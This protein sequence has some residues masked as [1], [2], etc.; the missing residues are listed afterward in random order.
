MKKNIFHLST[1]SLLLLI[2]VSCDKEEQSVKVDSLMPVNTGNTRT[3]KYTYFNNHEEN[4]DT[5]VITI[6]EKVL[7]NGYTCFAAA[8]ESPFNA[9]FLA[10]NDEFGNFVSYGGL[11]D[12]D[13]LVTPSI[14]FKKDAK[15]GDE[16]E[17]SMVS[18][19]WETG[20]FSETTI[21]VKC[22]SVDTLITTPKGD[23][24]CMAFETSINSGDHIF[25]HYYSM[26]VGQVKN[27]H[28]EGEYLFSYNELIDYVINW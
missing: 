5:T 25:R 4:I 16:W 27:E 26:N 28:Y 23:F 1:L 3:Y 17:Y 9:K 24:H 6:G 7:I 11:S 21:P 13:T 22:L 18:M 10:G 15:A 2:L 8:D 20:K 19:E 12:V 14:E